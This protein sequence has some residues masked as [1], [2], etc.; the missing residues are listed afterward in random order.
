M[1]KYSEIALKVLA[2]KQLKLIDKRAK[3]FKDFEDEESFLNFL[4]DYEPK[5]SLTID[6]LRNDLATS[7]NFDEG[8]ICVFDDE[9]PVINKN[10]KPSDNPYLLF[11]KG[12]INLLSDLNKNVAVIGL[13]TPTEAI[14]DREVR[15]V[16]ELLEGGLVIVSGL[17]KGC[18]A[19]AHKACVEN[20]GKTIAILPSS[21]HDIFPA[22]HK[23]LAR[24]IV[25]KGGLLLSEYHTKPENKYEAINRFVER[26]RLQ[27][28]FAKAIILIASYRKDDGDSGSR[29]AM[30]AAEKYAISRYIMYNSKIDHGDKMFGLNRDLF[31]DTTSRVKV[32]DKAMINEIIIGINENLVFKEKAP[33]FKQGS[34]F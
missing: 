14:K 13:T 5:I 1:I 23:S 2:A 15:M 22:E 24:E 12:D 7:E 31:E 33:I 18:D 3:F 26:D 27:A 9:F 20:D 25:A 32:I 10:V 17:A 34:L 19:I 16:K 21:I 6:K 8:F 29:H 28:M 11:Y 4:N 30:S